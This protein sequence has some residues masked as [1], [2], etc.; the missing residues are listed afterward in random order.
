MAEATQ[1][2]FGRQDDGLSMPEWHQQ[3]RQIEVLRIL[4]ADSDQCRNAPA[5]IVMPNW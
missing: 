3:F 4:I 5:W 1:R 2:P